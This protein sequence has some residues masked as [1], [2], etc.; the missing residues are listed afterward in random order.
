MT[1]RDETSTWVTA[2]LIY[3]ALWRLGIWRKHRAL[4]LFLVGLKELARSMTALGMTSHQAATNLNQ[5]AQA[6]EEAEAKEEGGI[7]PGDSGR[8]S[9]DGAGVGEVSSP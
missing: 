3:F 7:M 2:V 5:V 1:R 8:L 6:L 4:R 9:L